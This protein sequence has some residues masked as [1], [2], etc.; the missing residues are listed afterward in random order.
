MII[1]FI[2]RIQGL[3]FLKARLNDPSYGD[4]LDQSGGKWFVESAYRLYD[5]Y[6][7]KIN[8]RF[9]VLSEFHFEYYQ[10]LV[11]LRLL[12]KEAL[13]Q[14]CTSKSFKT[15]GSNN[16]P[17][18]KGIN[19]GSDDKKVEE[20]PNEKPPPAP[21]KG[22]HPYV[23]N[24]LMLDFDHPSQVD[25]VL[26]NLYKR[27]GDAKPPHKFCLCDEEHYVNAENAETFRLKAS[28]FPDEIYFYDLIRA[29]FTPR[30]LFNDITFVE[31]CIHLNENVRE[32]IRLSNLN[33]RIDGIWSCWFLQT[34]DHPN[35][36]D[37]HLSFK[38][39]R[40]IIECFTGN[41]YRSFLYYGD[42]LRSP[43]QLHTD[44]Y[45]RVRFL[46]LIS[47]MCR[48]KSFHYVRV[49]EECNGGKR[50]YYINSDL[51]RITLDDGCA[52]RCKVLLPTSIEWER[53]QSE[54][55]YVGSEIPSKLEEFLSLKTHVN[56]TL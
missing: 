11:G 30:T 48:L 13:Q 37:G 5:K 36:H 22:L 21:G 33:V 25:L 50:A 52:V 20:L 35:N 42:I 7:K 32:S 15:L 31:L 43:E 1:G 18:H 55:F 12:N 51:G 47:Y 6:I 19:S 28:D 53:S 46:E 39:W 14:F 49:V 34:V 38:L 26:S 40:N 17:E 4:L 41:K 23:L 54:I 45:K 27:F 8:R 24:S 2:K 44:M 3:S 16:T 29:L 10:K 56:I 9:K